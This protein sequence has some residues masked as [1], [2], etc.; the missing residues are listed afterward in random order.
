MV[1]SNDDGE[2]RL[3]SL[4]RRYL[5][6]RDRKNAIR[7]QTQTNKQQIRTQKR[8]SR[9]QKR[10]ENETSLKIILVIVSLVSF[11][12]MTILPQTVAIIFLIILIIIILVLSYKRFILGFGLVVIFMVVILF[13]AFIGTSYGDDLILRLERAGLPGQ[14]EETVDESGVSH[15]FNVIGEILTGDFDPTG[16][17]TSEAVQS[18]YATPENFDVVIEEVGPRKQYFKPNENISLSGRI[19]LI[20]GFDKTTT[21]TLGAKPDQF[22]AK[23]NEDELKQWLADN[24]GGVIDFTDPPE[25]CSN[26]TDWVCYISGSD[27]QN[28]FKMERIY[29]REFYCT[30]SGIDVSDEEVLSNLEVTWEYETSAVAGMQVYAF[31]PDVIDRTPDPIEKYDIDKDSLTSWYIGDKNVNLGLKIDSYGKEYVRAEST[32]DTNLFEAKNYLGI[33]ISNAGSG[34][35][36]E[37][38]SL[39]V[40]FPSTDGIEVS[41]Q[42]V[43]TSKDSYDLA[44]EGPTTELL[45][46]LGQDV[47]TKKFT[48]SAIELEKFEVLEPADHTAYYIPF[49][50]LEE[51]IGET[52]FQSFLAKVEIKY[53]YQESDSTTASVKP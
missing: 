53:K 32:D 7:E 28:T 2:G 14:V 41:N 8:D 11:V 20:S 49:V 42:I 15:Q 47:V 31:S 46:I 52:A 4:K 1:N 22:C 10:V 26:D 30:H 16:L 40:S 39:S 33:S 12:I 38:E 27:D 9:V 13:W 6:H 5:D 17:W 36:V 18:E 45:S 51:Y 37:L 3:A 19:N 25:G 44:F 34:D 35:M 21:I 24:S 43:R 29:N 23:E 50:V 48:L